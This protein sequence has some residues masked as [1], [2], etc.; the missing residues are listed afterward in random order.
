MCVLIHLANKTGSL[1]STL[2]P[3][4]EKTRRAGNRSY[5]FINVI[6]EEGIPTVDHPL[7]NLPSVIYL[8]TKHKYTGG[9]ELEL[10]KKRMAERC[11]GL[12]C[13]GSF[14]SWRTGMTGGCLCCRKY[15]TMR[16]YA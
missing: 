1:F 8:K 9:I 7:R 2:K 13:A 11:A 12:G 10:R 15:S 16:I 14:T 5:Q 6:E 4:N 3:V